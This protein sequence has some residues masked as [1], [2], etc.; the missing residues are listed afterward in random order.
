MSKKI[1]LADWAEQHYDPPPSAWTLRQWA[2]AGQIVP[3][4]E[5][6]GKSYYV[7]VDAKRVTDSTPTGAMAEFLA[8]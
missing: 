7:S 2:R 6:V 3:A 1:P 5:K 8:A 4:P